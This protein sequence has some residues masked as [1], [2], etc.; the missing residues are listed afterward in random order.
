[1]LHG[2]ALFKVDSNIP[3]KTTA[4]T[5][6]KQNTL[7][8]L[9]SPINKAMIAFNISACKWMLHKQNKK[10]SELRGGVM[11]SAEKLPQHLLN[12]G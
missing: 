10:S 7:V 3:L 11:I 8:D 12:S 4:T 1:M 6:K 5:I 9:S 2:S